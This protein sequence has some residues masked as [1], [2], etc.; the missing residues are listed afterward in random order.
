MLPHYRGI[1]CNLPA[2]KYCCITPTLPS[3]TE[4]PTVR[5]KIPNYKGNRIHDQRKNLG[6]FFTF[7][8]SSIVSHFCLRVNG[9]RKESARW[10]S[11]IS[12]AR[13]HSCAQLRIREPRIFCH[14][15]YITSQRLHSCLL[16]LSVLTNCRRRPSPTSRGQNS[17]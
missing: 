2:A 13:N 11:F 5:Q 14:G 10:G 3:I 16:N 7:E 1:I 4:S 15:T 12:C 9:I 17:P 8:P 6:L